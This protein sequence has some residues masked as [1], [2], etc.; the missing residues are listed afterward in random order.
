V[1]HSYS[2]FSAVGSSG[3]K[4]SEPLIPTFQGL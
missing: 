2:V 4:G 1:G 3:I